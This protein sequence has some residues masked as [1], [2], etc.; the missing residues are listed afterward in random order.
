[1]GKDLGE[2]GEGEGEVGL[3]NGG[4]WLTP[5]QLSQ[6]VVQELGLT[7]VCYSVLQ[8][9]AV[10]CSVLQCVAVCCSVLQCV[11]VCCS[12]LQC[13]AVCGNVSAVRE[14]GLTGQVLWL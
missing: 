6:A 12:V 8:C 11:A 5:L 13:L 7:V 9:V 3:R 10:C 4:K 14:L 2:G 1:M